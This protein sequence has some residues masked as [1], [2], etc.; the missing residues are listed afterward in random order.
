MKP[1]TRVELALEIA[2]LKAQHDGL[3]G[4]LN[5]LVAQKAKLREDVKLAT[6]KAHEACKHEELKL[7]GQVM[8][9]VADTNRAFEMMIRGIREH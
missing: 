9:Q 3:K 7:I 8:Q 1:K 6:V 5:E 2:H 4:L